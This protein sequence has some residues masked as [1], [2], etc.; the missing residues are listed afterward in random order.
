MARPKLSLYLG[1]AVAILLVT[2]IGFITHNETDLSFLPRFLA[3]FVPL[4]LAWFLLASWF[5]LFEHEIISNPKQLWRP[6][7]A[8]AFAGPFAAVLRSLIL[9]TAILPIFA[10]VLAAT[11]AFGMFLWRGLYLLI[12]RKL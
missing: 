8:M 1:D 2:L 11:S 6:V 7:F 5:G 12:Q 10:L 3:A 4:V 9:N